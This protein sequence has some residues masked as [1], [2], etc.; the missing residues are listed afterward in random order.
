M[1]ASAFLLNIAGTDQ[2]RIVNTIPRVFERSPF[3]KRMQHD[4]IGNAMLDEIILLSLPTK[5]ITRIPL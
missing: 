2:I 5:R 3:A 4:R 1:P